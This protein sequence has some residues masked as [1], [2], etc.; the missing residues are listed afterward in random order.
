MLAVG[1]LTFHNMGSPAY[2][3]NLPA[4]NFFG[5]SHGGGAN[6]EKLRPRPRNKRINGQHCGRKIIQL[7]YKR[8][9]MYMPVT[10]GQ[11]RS[12]L[13]INFGVRTR[14]GLSFAMKINNGFLDHFDR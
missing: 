14:L 9:K 2:P 5:M 12:D 13:T 6:R 3:H 7:N 8:S 10:R 11:H 4:G 1:R